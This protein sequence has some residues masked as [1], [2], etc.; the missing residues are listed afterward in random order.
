VCAVSTDDFHMFFNLTHV[1]HSTL[2][3]R[4]INVP[5]TH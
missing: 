5:E 1:G 2:R 3:L 4:A